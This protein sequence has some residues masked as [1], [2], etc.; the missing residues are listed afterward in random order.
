MEHGENM[1][2]TFFEQK[3]FSGMEFPLQRLME[4]NMKT[5]QSMSYLKP[6]DLMNIKKPEDLF[7]R[8]MDMFLQNSHMALNYM[9]D[10]FNILENH[11]LNASKHAEEHVKQAVSKVV[12]SPIVKKNS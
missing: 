6:G 11:W 10:T 8:N 9:R 1:K 7:E 2:N 3:F 4:L 5:I 12:A